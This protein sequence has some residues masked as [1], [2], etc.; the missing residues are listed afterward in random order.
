MFSKWFPIPTGAT[1]NVHVPALQLPNALNTSEVDL[2]ETAGGRSCSGGGGRASIWVGRWS[3]RSEKDQ[4]EHLALLHAACLTDSAD[5]WKPGERAP[6]K[7]HRRSTGP[8]IM[9]EALS[10]SLPLSLSLCP[11]LCGKNR[12]TDP[13]VQRFFYASHF[14]LDLTRCWLPPR[15]S[16]PECLCIGTPGLNTC[17]FTHTSERVCVMLCTCAEARACQPG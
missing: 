5:T 9:H 8:C 13:S 10:P 2:N 1:Y 4:P 15:V 3:W 7:S 6:C 11:L 14:H 17:V 16:L 12:S